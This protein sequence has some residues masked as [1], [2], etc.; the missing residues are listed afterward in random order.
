MIRR[1]KPQCLS[2]S[3]ARYLHRRGAA[4]AH[5]Q[6]VFIP[7]VESADDKA[8]LVV[9]KAQERKSTLMGDNALLRID[10]I[11][12]AQEANP[13]LTSTQELRVAI[14]AMR[15]EDK[16]A[17]RNGGRGYGDRR[18][19]RDREEMAERERATMGKGP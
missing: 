8:A 19:K 13:K 14:E 10:P 17:L 12:L 11:A 5:I 9:I 18:D 15:A 3:G 1:H 2:G 16:R 6:Q 4:G 7:L